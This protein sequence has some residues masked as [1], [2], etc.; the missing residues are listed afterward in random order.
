MIHER[1]KIARIVEELTM[2]FFALGAD[3]IQ[4]G[5]EKEGQDV[6]IDFQANYSPE[7]AHKLEQMEKELNCPKND[8]MRDVYWELAGSGEPEATEQLL[9]IG[10]MID[11][12]QIQTEE[13]KVHLKLYRKQ[14]E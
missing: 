1:K 3:R 11:K 2:F 9:L 5:I 13:G 14:Q 8:G 10:M 7:N 4:S 6:I 12:V